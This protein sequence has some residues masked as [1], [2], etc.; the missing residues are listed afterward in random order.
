[1]NDCRLG[2]CIIFRHVLKGEAGGA[3][4]P[5]ILADQ[6]APPGSGGAPH[7]YLP[8]QIF[9]LCNMPGTYTLIEFSKFEVETNLMAKTCNLDSNIIDFNSR[10]MGYKLSCC[11]SL[12]F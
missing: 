6:K 3:Y 11:G 1:M 9:R 12:L 2:T 4:A 8:P 10:P 5:Q 7:Y